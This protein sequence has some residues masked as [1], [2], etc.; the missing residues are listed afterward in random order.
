M[1][2]IH[3]KQVEHVVVRNHRLRWPVPDNLQ[4]LMAG[5]RVLGVFRR[6]KYLLWQFDNGHLLMHLG[7]SGSMR[8]VP[9][10]DPSLDQVGKH[11]HLDIVM[12]GKRFGAFYRPSSF[13]RGALGRG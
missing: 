10:S 8:I 7:M 6:A 2:H 5:R 11:D 4:Q 12:E 3:G 1:P 9:A 13:W